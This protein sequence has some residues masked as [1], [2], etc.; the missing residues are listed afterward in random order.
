MNKYATSVM[1]EKNLWPKGKS[2][3]A[4]SKQVVGIHSYPK[5][6]DRKIFFGMV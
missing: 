5:I 6:T 4:N 2:K 1:C 3:E